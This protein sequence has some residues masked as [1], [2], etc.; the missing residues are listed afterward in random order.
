VDFHAIV[1]LNMAL[2][3]PLNPHVTAASKI[4]NPPQ[5]WSGSQEMGKNGP[6][7]D[8]YQDLTLIIP[9][10]NEA[11]ALPQVLETLKQKC[12]GRVHE[13]ILVDDGSQDATRELALAAG[14]KVI[15]HSS[16]RG[17]G[18]S[19]KTGIRAAQTPFILIMDAEGQH[20]T[21]D[22][23]KLWSYPHECDMVVGARVDLFH[24]PIWRMP[25]KW[26]L[27]AIANHLV[28]RKIPD[29]NS[30]LRLFRKDTVTKYM[31]LCPNGFSF[32][33]TI[34][35]AFLSRG[36]SV[37]YVPI[38]VKPR[39]GN[40]TV[41]FGTGL[42]TMMLLLRLASLFNPLRLFVPLSLIIGLV[43]ILW[44]IPFLIAG[45]GLSVGTLL[46]IVT[47][48]LLF[49]LGMICDQIS[50]LRLERFE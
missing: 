28:R 9:A 21:D 40:S 37:E 17:Y 4:R 50:Q 10:F 36:Y 44:G 48:I 3:T 5:D 39:R 27:T 23:W 6:K 15:S 12:L 13:I 2:D 35:M 42:D 41:T 34:T 45:H 14:L 11:M 24:S 19:L 31:H 30:G 16:N 26:L 47:A 29:L 25:G 8:A 18:A 49:A 1:A 38:S 20:N 22:V 43:G 7:R 32:T 46:A 33:S